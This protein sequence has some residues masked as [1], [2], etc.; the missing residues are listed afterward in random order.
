M[1]IAKRYYLA[2]GAQN[3]VKLWDLR[4][5]KSFHS[6]DL[7]EGVVVNAVEWDYSGTYLAVASD[8]I[9]VYLGKTLNHIGTYGKHTKPVTDVKWGHN[10]SFLVSTSMD[11]SLKSWG[12][13][14][15]KGRKK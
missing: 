8:D 6:L 1:L 2:T 10:A 4:K 7:N 14:E 15:K 3:T 13:K 5:L 12:Y 11:R 9:K